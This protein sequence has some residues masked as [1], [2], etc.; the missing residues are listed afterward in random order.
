MKELFFVGSSLCKRV[1][2]GRVEFVDSTKMVFKGKLLVACVVCLLLCLTGVSRG[3]TAPWTPWD[4]LQGDAWLADSVT[5]ESRLDMYSVNNGSYAVGFDYA[6]KDGSSRGMNSLQFSVGGS[7]TGHMSS[8][9]L[10]GSFDVIC[11]GTKTYSDLL[12]LVAID[13]ST[14]P[15]DFSMSLGLPGQA[16]YSFDQ[17]ADFCYYDPAVL[18]YDAG[19]PSGYYSATNPTGSPLTYDFDSGMVSIYAFSGLSFDSAT[20]MNIEYAFENLPGKA[21]FSVYALVDGASFVY[22]TNRG[23]DDLN[24]GTAVVSTFEVLPEP[25]TILL[26][27][28]GAVGLLRQRK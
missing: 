7:S 21:V 18:S 6:K 26:L 13:S 2:E 20:A 17:A 14:L 3:V 28:L 12:V 16:Q 5:G 9:A 22:H 19:R 27:S 24:D 4:A 8:S 25:A 10:T 1:A 11:G 15:V 23:V